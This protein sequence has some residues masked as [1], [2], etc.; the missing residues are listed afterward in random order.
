[1]G[2]SGRSDGPMAWSVSLTGEGKLDGEHDDERV[3]HKAGP[4]SASAQASAM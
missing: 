2:L 1:M 4:E 3:A